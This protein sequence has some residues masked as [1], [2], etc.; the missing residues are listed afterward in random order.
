MNKSEHGVENF[1]QQ[2]GVNNNWTQRGESPEQDGVN[3]SWIGEREYPQ[4]D[5]VNNNWIHRGETH[6]KMERITAG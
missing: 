1:P 5:G 2:D 6:N 3:N 4:Q